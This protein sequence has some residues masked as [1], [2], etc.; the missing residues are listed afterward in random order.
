MPQI[1]NLIETVHLQHHPQR[2]QSH[3][4]RQHHWAITEN[5]LEVYDWSELKQRQPLGT[6]SQTDHD[7]L[8]QN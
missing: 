7:H 6:G 8:F 1:E 2:P 3:R 5:L 4:L